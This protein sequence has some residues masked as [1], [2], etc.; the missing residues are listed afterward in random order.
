MINII[1][2]NP[3]SF[4]AKL[5]KTYKTKKT[6]ELKNNPFKPNDPPIAIIPE[7]TEVLCYGYYEHDWY[8][9]LD[10]NIT[11]YCNKAELI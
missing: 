6:I 10:E 7:G 11:G 2:H 4:D 9:V 3:T 5:A 1:P 8:Y